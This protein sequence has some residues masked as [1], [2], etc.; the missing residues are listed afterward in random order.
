MFKNQVQDRNGNI[1]LKN[2]EK[3]LYILGMFSVSKLWAATE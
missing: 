3:Y 1:E 2:E